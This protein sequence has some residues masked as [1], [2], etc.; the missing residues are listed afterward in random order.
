MDKENRQ[1][2]RESFLSLMLRGLMVLGLIGLLAGIVLFLLP[3]AQSV[4]WVNHLAEDGQLESFSLRRYQILKAPVLAIFTLLAGLITW[5]LVNFSATKRLI[6]RFGAGL[7]LWLKDFTRGLQ[8]LLFE[9]KASLTRRELL[10]FVLLLVLAFVLRI[11]LLRQP[12]DHD[13][14]YT[15]VVFAFQPLYK[16]LSDYHF[17]NNHV[18]HTFLVHLVYLIFGPREWAVRLPAFLAGISLAPLGYVLA[19]RWFGKPTA[20]LA[21]VMIVFMPDLIRYSVRAR[22]YSLM[23]M[24]TLLVL[25]CAVSVK[26][27]KNPAVWILLGLFGALGFYT[28]PIMAYPL[29]M[30]YVWLGLSW[31]VGDVDATYRRFEFPVYLLGSGILAALLGLSLYLPIFRN[32]GV[33]GVFANPYVEALT[34]ATYIQDVT[35]R[36]SETWDVLN[37]GIVPG[38]GWMLGI[39]FILAVIFSRR[40][41]GDKLPFPLVGM[42]CIVIL[43]A[44]QR[45]NIYTRTWHFL[46]PLLCMWMAMGLVGLLQWLF[47]LLPL[48]HSSAWIGGVVAFFAVLFAVDGVGYTAAQIPLSRAVSGE[49]EQATLYLKDHLLPGDIVVITAIDDAPMWF[50]F[51]KYGLGQGYFS[52]SQ[53]FER[54]FVVVTRTDNQTID[55]VIDDRGP[56]PVFFDFATTEQAAVFGGLDVYLIE[57]NHAAILREYG[58]SRE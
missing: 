30:V 10:V 15:A 26:G 13:E 45:P 56:D 44:V 29:V 4:A 42:I 1:L 40:M 43:V 25:L 22:G 52:R 36:L 50:Y 46:M 57:A 34:E 23:A 49:V 7:R 12:M 24:F 47:D 5:G 41:S 3:Y 38:V 51:E 21:G 37:W 27:K 17:P 58:E 28:L 9:I 11:F 55:F 54:A 2:R 6:K 8:V 31:L 33:S 53:P 19:R 39:G 16:G 18:F 20:L 35:Q 14:S 48:K 32:W